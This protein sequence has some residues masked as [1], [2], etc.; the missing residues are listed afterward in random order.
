MVIVG[1]LAM[2]IAGVVLIT[3]GIPRFP[4]YYGYPYTSIPIVF[5]IL[6]IIMLISGTLLFYKT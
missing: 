2:I 6:G 4:I 5:S 3:S 1:G